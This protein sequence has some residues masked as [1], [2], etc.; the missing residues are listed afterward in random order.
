MTKVLFFEDGE[1]FAEWFETKAGQSEV[2]VGYYRKATGKQGMSWSQ[3]VDVALCYGWIDGIR[4]TMDDES[5]R[6]RFTPRKAKSLWS[7]VKVKKALTLI[8]EGRMKPEGLAV[9][10][11]RRDEKGYKAAD[12][13]IPLSKAFEDRIR[14]NARA[15]TVF[16]RLAPSYKRESAW[17]VMSAKREAT[18][19]KRLEVLIRSSEAGQKIPHLGKSKPQRR[20]T[21]GA[22]TPDARS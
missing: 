14:A 7:A 20:E 22:S 1:A 10:A 6:I 5:Y 3:S 12:R 13:D 11:C 2:W 16:S 19:S 21:G 17:W 8:D 9:F 4:Q 18:R 15:W